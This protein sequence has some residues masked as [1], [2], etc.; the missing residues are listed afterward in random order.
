MVERSGF[1]SPNGQLVINF[2]GLGSFYKA[3]G[4]T[5]I[6]DDRIHHVAITMASTTAA[7]ILLYVDGIPQ[8][9]T[10]ISGTNGGSWG[11]H[12][13]WS[14]GN[15]TNN[16]SGDYGIGGL[17]D[18]VAVY[19]I[20]L[21]PERIAE[22][23]EAGANGFADEPTGDRIDR[24]LNIVDCGPELCD[25][26]TGDTVAG[27][28]S[29]D[30]R[31]VADYIAAIVE[32]EQGFF[33]VD[34]HGGGLLK[35]RGRYS[36]FL[37]TRSTTS[38]RRSPTQP[39]AVGWYRPEIA[40]EPNSVE[41]I[42]NVVDVQ[43]RGGTESLEDATSRGQYGAQSHTITTEAPT[44]AGRPVRRG[45]GFSRG[46]PNRQVRMRSLPINSHN[47]NRWI[48]STD[49]AGCR[50]DHRPATPSTSAPPSPTSSSSRGSPIDG[51]PTSRGTRP[52]TC[53]T[54]TSAKSGSG[55]PPSGTKP[56]TGDDLMPY[57]D[58]N[59]IHNPATGTVAPATWGTRS[60]TTSSS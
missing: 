22:H 31:S 47:E 45:S 50:P 18:E 10:T 6:D 56:S 12:L 60:A 53:Q 35:F 42:I 49:L 19:P 30:G 48:P 25:L 15:T 21:T 32:S 55:A 41:S 38:R 51:P 4:H 9:K 57:V 59:T 40:P 26:A 7:D 58:P 5:R 17:I 28:A 23:Y 14:V 52:T 46:M 54:P 16:G 43:W 33:F 34:H 37:E 11:A 2:A 36:R 44:P 20:V 13:I 24:V 8:T 27:P 1:G 29:Y 3:R 39:A